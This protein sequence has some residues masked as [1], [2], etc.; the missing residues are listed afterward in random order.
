MATTW[1]AE[2]AA[3]NQKADV[4]GDNNNDN[5]KYEACLVSGQVT[6]QNSKPDK[7]K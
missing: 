3:Y 7:Q 1:L 4:Y 6:R 2:R 5:M